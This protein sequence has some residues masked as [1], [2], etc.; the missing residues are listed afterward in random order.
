MTHALC[1]THI[2]YVGDMTGTGRAV[3]LRRS[4]TPSTWRWASKRRK[5]PE[6]PSC[7]SSSVFS[8]RPVRFPVVHSL[9]RSPSGHSAKS[10]CVGRGGPGHKDVAS[11]TRRKWTTGMKL[12]SWM[13]RSAL[14][15]VSDPLYREATGR[16]GVRIGV[17]GSLPLEPGWESL[18]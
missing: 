4:G 13:S 3:Y 12:K 11:G 8:S 15:G 7:L 9:N 5:A 1:P 6:S 10:G 18:E 14:V 17:G 16:G 2:S